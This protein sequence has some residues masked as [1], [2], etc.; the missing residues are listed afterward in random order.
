MCL[1]SSKPPSSKQKA[2]IKHGWKVFREI[3]GT[4]HGIYNFYIV[5]KSITFTHYVFDKPSRIGWFTARNLENP[6]AGFHV[7][8]RKK[9]A[10]F[11][12]SRGHYAWR[13]VEVRQIISIGRTA[14]MGLFNGRPAL[15]CKKIRLI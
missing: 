10:E 6:E 12:A 2:R 7:F 8:L 3:N 14:G 13:K 4:L 11:V 5:C 1:D 15:T 9:D